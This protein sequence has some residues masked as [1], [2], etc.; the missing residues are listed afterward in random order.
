MSHF[1]VFTGKLPRATQEAQI[2]IEIRQAIATEQTQFTPDIANDPK[3]INVVDYAFTEANPNCW[4]VY[5][6][7]QMKPQ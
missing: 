7:W 5:A 6:K 3:Q 4:M 2:P 1:F